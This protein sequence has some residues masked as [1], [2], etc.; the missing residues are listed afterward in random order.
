MNNKLMVLNTKHQT[1]DFDYKPMG[2]CKALVIFILIFILSCILLTVL[3]Y[4]LLILRFDIL[5][6]NHQFLIIH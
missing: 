5:V 2:G 6:E 4:G 3:Y 1:E